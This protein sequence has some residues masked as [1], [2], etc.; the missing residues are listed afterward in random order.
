MTGE[1]YMAQRGWW[2]WARFRVMAQ[3]FE[4]HNSYG[5]QYA[6]TV[7]TTLVAGGLHDAEQEPPVL[8][9]FATMSASHCRTQTFC[10]AVYRE[11]VLH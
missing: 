3:R 9:R 2:R 5:A 1:F 6:P 8:L 10:A 4:H 11:L 7:V